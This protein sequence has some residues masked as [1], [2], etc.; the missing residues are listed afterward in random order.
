M[1]EN[2][3]AH[4]LK[5]A[6]DPTSALNNSRAATAIHVGIGSIASRPN[7]SLSRRIARL[8]DIHRPAFLISRDGEV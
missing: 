7:K 3:A 5:E 6:F 2:C 1:L 8:H 4:P